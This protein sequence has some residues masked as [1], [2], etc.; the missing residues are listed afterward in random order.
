MGRPLLSLMDY[1][2]REPERSVFSYLLGQG[3]DGGSLREIRRAIGWNYE[4]RQRRR[5]ATQ[6]LQKRLLTMVEKRYRERAPRQSGSRADGVRRFRIR[7]GAPGNEV[8]RLLNVERLM[9]SD[10]KW[11]VSRREGNTV[12][13]GLDTRNFDPMKQL[14]V[15]LI[16]GD[17]ADSLRRLWDIRAAS[18][19]G[20]EYDDFIERR[21][22]LED[23]YAKTIMRGEKTMP[24]D[25]ELKQFISAWKRGISAGELDRPL[26]ISAVLEVGDVIQEASIIEDNLGPNAEALI[27]GDSLD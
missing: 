24:V 8:R 16:M 14:E 2:G 18:Y 1:L 21:R 9:S 7:G 10:L 4:N 13:Y 17:L 11:I 20:L 6:L 12:L 3:E 5:V 25:R 19:L 22:R 15:G 23:S 26:G 27:R